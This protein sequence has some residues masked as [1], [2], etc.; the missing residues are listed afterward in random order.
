MLQ[1]GNKA[2]ELKLPL[3]GGGDFS[4]YEALGRGEVLLAFFKVSCPVCQYTFP[5]LERFWQGVKGRGIQVVGI[6]QDDASATTGFAREFGVTFPIA[7]DAPPYAVSSAYGLSN[8]PTLVRVSESGRV[9]DVIVGWSKREMEEVYAPY[10][11]S[12]NA[13]TPLFRAEENV[14]EFKAG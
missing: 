4:L 1:T 8:V 9:A 10:T 2:P 7:L 14:A 11:D 5:Y 6:S 12:A 3:L 13:G